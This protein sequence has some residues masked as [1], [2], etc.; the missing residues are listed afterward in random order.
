MA[1]TSTLHAYLNDHRA[2]ATGALHLLRRLQDAD[3]PVTPSAFLGDLGDRVEA[4]LEVLEDVMTR[5]DIDHDTARA[6]AGWVGEHLS[7]LRLSPRLTGSQ[8]LTHVLELEAISMGIQGKVML[9]H[10]LRRAVGDDTRLRDVDFD[11]LIERGRRQ[12][13]DVQPHRLEMAGRA[14]GSE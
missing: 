11:E 8:H 9:W 2:G 3:D 12:F 4:D 10:S 7:R 1:D 6:A 5:L 14:F 13:D